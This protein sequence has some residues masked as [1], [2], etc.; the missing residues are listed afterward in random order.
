MA[1]I[2]FEVETLDAVEEE[3]REAYIE[4]EGKFRFDPDRYHELRAKPLIKKNQE[5]IGKQK[6]LTDQVKSLEGVK[7][8]AETDVDK[9]AAEKDRQIADLRSELRESKIWTP[10]QQLAVKHGVMPDRL[11]AVMTIL[12]ANGRF[13]Q[14]DGGKLIFK[15]KFGDET[16]TTPARA[17]EYHLKEEMPWAF[18]ASQTGGSGAKNGVKPGAGRVLTRER[19]DSLTEADR[20][21]YVSEGYRI[22]D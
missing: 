12:R 2:Q 4:K 10:V 1:D 15:D 3:I 11:D 9:V 20:N 14:D 7:R 21:K 6:T 8:S 18:A 19:Y 13:D 16:A 5:L 17:F 22:V